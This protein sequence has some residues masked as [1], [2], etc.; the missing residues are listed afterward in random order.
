MLTISEHINCGKFTVKYY[1]VVKTGD[2][3]LM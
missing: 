2:L 3:Q 1:I